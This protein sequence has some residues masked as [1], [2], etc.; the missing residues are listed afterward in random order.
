M[1]DDARSFP[2]SL[3]H[4]GVPWMVPLASGYYH[5]RDALARPGAA[6]NFF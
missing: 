1:T 2:T 4:T 5:L 3:F 6:S